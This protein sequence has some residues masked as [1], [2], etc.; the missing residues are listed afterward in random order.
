MDAALAAVAQQCLAATHAGSLGFAAIVGM[1]IEAGFE[2]YAV[3]YRRGAQTFYLPDGQWLD[4]PLPDQAGL[5]AAAFDAAAV[6]AQIRWAQSGD[7]AYSY[8]AFS[9]HATAAGC[10]G[11]L[12]SFPGRR[13]VYYGRTSEVHIELFPQ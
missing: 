11:Y 7:P 9:R 6:E 3:D 8:Q 13:V 5:A 10:A 4:F 2:G 12:V 1:L